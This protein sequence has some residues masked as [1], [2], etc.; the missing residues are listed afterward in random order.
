MK[1]R[2]LILLITILILGFIIS[3]DSV[4]SMPRNDDQSFY[5]SYDFVC[6]L[7]DYLR[8]LSENYSY[9]PQTGKTYNE[10]EFR[11]V[12]GYKANKIYPEIGTIFD[13][14]SVDELGYG[15]TKFKSGEKVKIRM[16]SSSYIEEAG[17]IS[18][19]IFL[20]GP[21]PVIMLEF[22]FGDP[23]LTI[24]GESY[25]LEEYTT[26]T[27]AHISSAHWY[28]NSQQSFIPKEDEG[29]ISLY[30]IKSGDPSS[31]KSLEFQ[32]K[33]KAEFF[34]TKTVFY[35][36]ADESTIYSFEKP[37]AEGKLEF[38]IDKNTEQKDFDT[39][40]TYVAMLSSDG[41][42]YK[43]IILIDVD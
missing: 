42:Y 17:F 35:N 11:K 26:A 2:T 8:D 23:V 1:K 22:L 37:N 10:I 5:Y 9:F 41:K 15:L 12:T 19:S 32:F 14:S 24:N 4:V 20:N 36:K 28:N 31:I 38:V 34:I 29:L 3:C 7:D 27:D 39:I 43:K 18:N 21:A 25:P 16:G 6:T 13:I 40:L 33:E 30:S